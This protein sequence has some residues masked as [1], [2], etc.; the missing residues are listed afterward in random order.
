MGKSRAHALAVIVQEVFAGPHAGDDDDSALLALE[1]LHGAHLDRREVVLVQV[2]SQL[3]HLKSNFT[4]ALAQRGQG[5]STM[6]R[7]WRRYGEM[8]PMSSIRIPDRLQE[9][10]SARRFGSVRSLTD[11][12]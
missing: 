10:N 6:H 12:S 11:A 3:L 2:Q 9:K 5:S 4:S 8:T 7:T 1:L